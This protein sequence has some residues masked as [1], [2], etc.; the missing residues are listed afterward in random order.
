MNSTPNLLRQILLG[1][2]GCFL[3]GKETS[4]GAELMT[5]FSRRMDNNVARLEALPLH[6]GSED[7]V[8]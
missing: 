1:L 2:F 3:V 5:T 6:N 8:P 7:A 4:C